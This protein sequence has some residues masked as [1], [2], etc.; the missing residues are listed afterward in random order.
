MYS[1][2]TMHGVTD[3]DRRTL[4]KLPVANHAAWQ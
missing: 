4:L 1:L 2:A 3:P